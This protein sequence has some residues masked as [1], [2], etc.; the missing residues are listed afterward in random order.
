MKH[1]FIYLASQ[2]PRRRELLTQMGVEHRLLL[3]LPDEDAEALEASSPHESPK[4][5]VQRVTLSKLQAAQRRRQQLGWPAAPIL[6]ADTT[7]A[8]GKSIMGKPEIGRAHV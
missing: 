4:A 1:P 3:P 6:C 2:S 8:L 5:Y 7:V